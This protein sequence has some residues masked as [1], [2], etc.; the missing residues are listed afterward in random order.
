MFVPRSACRIVCLVAITLGLLLAMAHT[1]AAQPAMAPG[2]Q[3][4]GYGA[5]P[6]GPTGY[7]A[8]P[9]GNGSN[10][11]SGYGS[12]NP[13]GTVGAG[14]YNSSGMASP[15]F[16]Y[17]YN[18]YSQNPGMYGGGYSNMPG[19]SYSYPVYPNLVWVPTPV[20]PDRVASY[21]SNNPNEWP[22]GVSSYSN[23]GNNSYPYTLVAVYPTYVNSGYGGNGNYGYSPNGVPGGGGQVPANGYPGGNPLNIAGTWFA[24]DNSGT[25]QLVI[26]PDGTL[27][28]CFTSANS[29]KQNLLR[30]RITQI[31]LGQYKA[32]YG[33]GL[34]WGAPGNVT[35]CHV[36]AFHS[37]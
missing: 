9:Y 4:P 28:Y 37:T 15:A 17:G 23:P 14:G 8:N 5:Q 25:I 32:F 1:G 24:S 31:G 22:Y 35:R 29:D 11:S 12:Y 13:Y 16:G 36:P 3:Y 26:G 7:T 20:V 27:N 34:S 10:Y 6:Y 33:N 30:G 21:V 2:T 18:P 19:P